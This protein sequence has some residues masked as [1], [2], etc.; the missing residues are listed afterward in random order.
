MV[1]FVFLVRMLVS[2]N[3]QPLDCNLKGFSSDSD[4]AWDVLS[5][6]ANFLK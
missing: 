4:Y 2:A 3:F 5:S 1:I 6:S